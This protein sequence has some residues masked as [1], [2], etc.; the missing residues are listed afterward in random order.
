MEKR[1]RQERALPKY[2]ESLSAP[3]KLKLLCRV[4]MNL[5]LPRREHYMTGIAFNRI[6]RGSFS[7]LPAVFREPLI[8]AFNP[9]TNTFEDEFL[10][11]KPRAIK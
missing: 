5:P 7:Q 2:W 9:E 1:Q 8:Q 6:L 10:N 11:N 3:L 4:R